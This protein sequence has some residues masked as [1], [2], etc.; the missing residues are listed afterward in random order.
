MENRLVWINEFQFLD[1]KFDDFKKNHHYNWEQ[2]KKVAYK[3]DYYSFLP[4]FPTKEIIC[5]WDH[6]LGLEFKLDLSKKIKSKEID[7]ICSIRA[8]EILHAA[9]TAQLPI[10]IHWSGG[11]DS[12]LV[13]TAILKNFLSSNLKQVYIALNIDSIKENS[14]FFV[15]HILHKFKLVD[16]S[17]W[18]LNVD[19]LK[20]FVH[21][22][23]HFADQLFPTGPIIEKEKH[24]P[25]IALSTLDNNNELTEIILNDAKSNGVELTNLGDYYWWIAFNYRWAE[26][27]IRDLLELTTSVDDA[28]YFCYKNNFIPWFNCDDFQW[29]SLQNYNR[30]EKM[31]AELYKQEFK[32]Y[33]FEYDKNHNYYLYKQKIGSTRQKEIPRPAFFGLLDNGTSITINDSNIGILL[34]NF[35]K[36]NKN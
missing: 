26:V 23:G 1:S 34:D 18:I 14:D 10:M 19:T 31:T 9:Q 21:V 25:G 7:E 15:K 32:K 20:R 27:S 17:Q 11:I 8:K 33:I 28:L 4:R 29:W 12:T 2:W 35:F 30:S 3:N 6:H 22:T 13:V 36:Q 5:P 24:S 16:S